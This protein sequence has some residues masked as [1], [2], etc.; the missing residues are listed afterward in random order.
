MESK[1]SY[2]HSHAAHEIIILETGAH[3]LTW[4]HKHLLWKF[5]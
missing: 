5:F 4:E 2:H 1:V 3:A